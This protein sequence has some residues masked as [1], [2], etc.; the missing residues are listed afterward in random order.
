MKPWWRQRLAGL[1]ALP[2]S[3]LPFAA[4]ATMTPEGRLLK[5]K[6]EVALS[7]PELPTLS[8]AQLAAARRVAPRFEG[9]VMSLVYHGIGTGSD[10]EDRFVLSPERFGEHLATLR[11][12]GLRTVTAREVA[13]A[14]TGGKPLPPNAVM[15][16]FDDGRADALLYADP[17]LEQA[18]MRATMF[19]ITAQAS[20]PGV[21]Y[22][23]W[24]KLEAASR[25][26]RW[27]LQSHTDS[28]HHEQKV[29]G[30]L[31]PALTS[32]GDGE[33]VAQYRARVRADL[34][35]ATAA[36][37]SHTGRRP[38]AF[39][40]PFGAYGADRTNSPAVRAVLEHEVTRQYA[41]AFHQDDQLT[42]P[43]TTPIDTRPQL[44]RLEVGDWTGTTLLTRIRQAVALTPG[45]APTEVPVD[46]T[47]P[48]PPPAPAPATD[49][50]APAPAGPG[51]APAAAAPAPSRPRTAA[52]T[53]RAP[54]SGSAP[55]PASAPVSSGGR[56][57][58]TW[59]PPATTTPTTSKPRPPSTTSPP[60]TSPP[61]TS[62]P[63]NCGGRPN[64]Q[65]CKK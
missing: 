13:A 37:R 35:K 31:L 36:L 27:D 26:G 9:G 7:P 24:D 32:L 54:S 2:L 48:P 41:I 39:A 51:P 49:G 60:T 19:V 30:T 28:L 44:R 29:K 42:V 17:L 21:Y 15:I 1:L 62:Q 8:G 38:V 25:S 6:V 61:T 56:T 12:A 59:R 11:A 20:K 18:R 50:P 63:T 40:Y 3:V 52:A 33:S 64:G 45:Q 46:P 65:P 43:L 5:G 10:G 47:A 57:I 4:Y 34:A 22:A 14:F 16:T 55:A 53:T 58:S 23:S